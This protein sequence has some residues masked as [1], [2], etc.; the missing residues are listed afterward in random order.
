M[1]KCQKHVVFKIHDQPSLSCSFQVN[2]SNV[3]LSFPSSVQF[4]YLQVNIVNSEVAQSCPTLLWPPW[5]VACQLPPSMGFPS[6]WTHCSGFPF[7][8]S[9]HLPTPGIEPASP[10]LAEEFFTV[11]LPGKP[12]WIQCL[13]LCKFD[14]VLSKSCSHL[15]KYYHP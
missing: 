3:K 9:G 2:M 15:P 7:P 13:L 6:W 14:P 4:S 10:T 11:E 12:P 1:P 8:S 5:T